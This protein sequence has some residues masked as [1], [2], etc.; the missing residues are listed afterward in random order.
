MN[1]LLYAA[2]SYGEF[3]FDETSLALLCC[4]SK[5]F[6]HLLPSLRELVSLGSLRSLI[7]A[8]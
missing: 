5:E 8:F 2:V 7:N 1:S 6:N 3:N 4:T